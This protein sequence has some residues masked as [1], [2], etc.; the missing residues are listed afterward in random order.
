MQGTRVLYLVRELDS[1]KPSV[2]AKER[3][4]KH[5]PRILYLPYLF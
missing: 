1:H 3:K 2:M 5:E 4:R